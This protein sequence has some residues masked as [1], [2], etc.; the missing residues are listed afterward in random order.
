MSFGSENN[1]EL[2]LQVIEKSPKKL[3]AVSLIIANFA[4]LFNANV[5]QFRDNNEQERLISFFVNLKQIA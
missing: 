4:E 5:N 2:D 3:K 1:Y